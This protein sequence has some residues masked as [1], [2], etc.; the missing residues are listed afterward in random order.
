MMQNCPN[1]GKQKPPGVAFCSQCGFNFQAYPQG[2]ARPKRNGLPVPA[3]IGICIAVVFVLFGGIYFITS[4][5]DPEYKTA[6]KIELADIEGT[7]ELAAESK[8]D[9]MTKQIKISEDEI[10][11]DSGEKFVPRYSSV[12][13]D[14]TLI[15]TDSNNIFTANRMELRL[16]KRK[17]NNKDRVVLAVYVDEDTGWGYYIRK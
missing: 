16:E 13:N 17:I 2:P 12:T 3:I 5:N 11:T 9:A 14:D 8:S 15:I 6:D 1:C 10:S 7:W 4:N